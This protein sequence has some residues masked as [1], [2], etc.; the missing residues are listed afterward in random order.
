MMN[1]NM[2]VGTMRAEAAG[3]RADPQSQRHRLTPAGATQGSIAEHPVGV[4]RDHRPGLGTYVT[5]E[6][7]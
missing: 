6:V 1:Q 3:R 2:A 5:G 4:L 7:R